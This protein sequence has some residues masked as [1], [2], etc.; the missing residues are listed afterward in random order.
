MVAVGLMSGTSLDG[1]D[2]ALVSIRPRGWSYELDLLASGTVPF[3][4]EQR[5][6]I[7]AVLPPNEPSPRATAMLD[8]EVGRAF[9]EAARALAGDRSIDYIASHGLTIYH[10]GAAHL[11][12]QI[13]DPSVIREIAGA[14][15]LAD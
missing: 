2:A 14:P 13:G 7:L 3:S 9:G 5:E 8:V 15:R 6:R 4:A 11:P 1:I 10:D 12:V